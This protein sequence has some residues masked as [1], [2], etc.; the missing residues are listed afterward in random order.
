MTAE[1][2][3]THPWLILRLE[4]RE[5][6]VSVLQVIEV[7]RMVALAPLPE[8]PAWVAGALN[9]RGKGVVVLDLRARLG[10]PPRPPD[11]DTLIVI[12]ATSREPLALLADE[13]V[14]ILE[15]PDEA[16][17]PSDRLAGASPLFTALAEAGE[18]LILVLDLDRL[19][20]AAQQPRNYA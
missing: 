12:V 10:L 9:L 16:L 1:G 20:G 5:Y 4:N 11:L 17:K 19:A 15:L 3:P 18:R 7:V 2:N 14:E 8:A 6:A 13:V